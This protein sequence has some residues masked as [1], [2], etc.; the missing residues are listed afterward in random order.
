MAYNYYNYAIH[1]HYQDNCSNIEEH[2]PVRKE[3]HKVNLLLNTC[4]PN[5]GGFHIGEEEGKNSW[6]YLTPEHVVP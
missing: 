6:H 5:T 3:K 4:L 2:L 1:L